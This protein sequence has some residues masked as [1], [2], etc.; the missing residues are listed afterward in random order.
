MDALAKHAAYILTEAERLA[1]GQSFAVAP[2]TAGTENLG[3]QV[4]MHTPSTAA[5]G[6]CTPCYFNLDGA[7]DRVPPELQ[8]KMW[9]SSL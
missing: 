5:I 2:T 3:M 1:A 7:I 8:M 9:R 4:L 6:G